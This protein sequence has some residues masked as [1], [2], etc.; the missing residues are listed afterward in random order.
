MLDEDII[1]A[2]SKIQFDLYVKEYFVNMTKNART[3][4][5]TNC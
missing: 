5:K 3:L 1:I 4:H 2:T